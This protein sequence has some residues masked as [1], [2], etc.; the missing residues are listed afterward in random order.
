MGS[1][2][3]LDSDGKGIHGTVGL[4]HRMPAPVGE[5]HSAMR[6]GNQRSSADESINRA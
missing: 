4:S 6:M 2:S 5:S 1:G 3:E